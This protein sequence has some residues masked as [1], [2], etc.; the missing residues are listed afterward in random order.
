MTRAVYEREVLDTFR[1][2]F[3]PTPVRRDQEA[4]D[5]YRNRIESRAQQIFY[6]ALAEFK[7]KIQDAMALSDIQ[8][9]QF[10]YLLDALHDN[11]PV[12]HDWDE[13]IK[14]ANQ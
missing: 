11:S 5:Q 7:S 8:R 4:D 14:E 1:K 3:A 13:A 6:P 10:Q 9:E 12:A 2:M